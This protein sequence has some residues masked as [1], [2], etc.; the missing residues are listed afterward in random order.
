MSL[1]G[2]SF[3]QSLIQLIKQSL[4]HQAK[5]AFL[6]VS[7]LCQLAE[8]EQKKEE[9]AEK[10]RRKREREEKALKEKE[11]AAKK[12]KPKRAARKP[13]SSAAKS[14]LPDDESSDPCKKCVVC[15]N[16]S[17]CIQCRV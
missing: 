15:A 1:C 9:A 4:R 7:F 11:K 14:P 10:E 17:T 6:Q 3:L 16:I 2:V 5:H 13:Q 8:K 12:Q